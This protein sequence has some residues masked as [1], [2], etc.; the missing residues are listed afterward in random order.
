MVTVRTGCT[1]DYEHP[2][3]SRT[4][5]AEWSRSCC[6]AS[7]RSPQ[8]RRAS[9]AI[10]TTPSPGASMWV[11]ERC[12]TQYSGE[13]RVPVCCRFL[14]PRLLQPRAES[15]EVCPLRIPAQGRLGCYCLRN[16]HSEDGGNRSRSFFLEHTGHLREGRSIFSATALWLARRGRG[17][18]W[19]LP[20]HCTA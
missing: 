5:L 1:P 18:R 6:Q 12:T 15:A 20:S 7:L 17:N 14:G 4:T 3:Q 16:S 8:C 19:E 10:A 11:N 2:P 9:R 13:R